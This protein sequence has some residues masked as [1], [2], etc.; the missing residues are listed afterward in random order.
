LPT[1]AC[2]YLLFFDKKVTKSKANPI[3]HATFSLERKG[4]AIPIYRD[5]PI[6]MR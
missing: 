4:G 1:V 2:Y 6:L 5:K 3:S